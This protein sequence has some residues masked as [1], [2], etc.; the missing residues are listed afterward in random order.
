MRL[1]YALLVIAF[2]IGYS[3]I[4]SQ[5][6]S[7]TI[8]VNRTELNKYL[9]EHT[10]TLSPGVAVGILQD[11]NLIFKEA[12]G[13][14][15]ISTKK[16][17]SVNSCFNMASLTKQFTAMCILLL[18][19]SGKLATS[20]DIRKYLPEFPEYDTVITIDNLLHHTSGIKDYVMLLQLSGNDIWSEASTKKVFEL[21]GNQKSLNFQPGSQFSYS[22]S[23]YFLLGEIIRRVSGLTLSRFASKYIFKPLGM[24][25]TFYLDEPTEH[26]T[27]QIPLNYERVGDSIFNERTISTLVV[28]STGLYTTMEDFAKWDDNLY[29]NQLGKGKQE[30]IDKL[31]KRGRLSNGKEISYGAGIFVGTYKGQPFYF[32]TGL[33]GGFHTYYYRLPKEKTSMV[34]FSNGNDIISNGLDILDI[35]LFGAKID[36]KEFTDKPVSFN[37]ESTPYEGFFDYTQGNYTTI[38]SVKKQIRFQVSGQPYMSLIPV[39]KDVFLTSGRKLKLSFID[40]EDGIFTKTLFQRAGSNRIDTLFRIKKPKDVFTGGTYFSK[41]LRSEIKLQVKNDLIQMVCQGNLIAEFL[42]S[43]EGLLIGDGSTIQLIR[44]EQNT[45]IFVF[46]SSR[47]K[48]IVFI[49]K[50]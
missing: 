29:V 33:F 47:T 5:Q 35:L 49:Q 28:G 8:V 25:K 34:I 44:D 27:Y 41:E 48:N 37:G 13:F 39:D 6:L 30:M 17:L 36:N 43:K 2:C 7:S 20:D 12:Y 40:P 1:K 38:Q 46:N 26:S 15:D 24:Y 42:Q 31:F 45:N 3:F 11:G 22:N 50:N 14:D 21:L 23:N 19:E 16:P 18:E 4:Y 9:H 10:S 32:H